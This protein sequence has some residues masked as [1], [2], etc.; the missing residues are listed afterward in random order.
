M[1]T[2]PP[3]SELN[4]ALLSLEGLLWGITADDMINRKEMEKLRQWKAEH[5]EKIHH[6][7]VADL[8]RMLD[9]IMECHILKEEEKAFLEAFCADYGHC[10][11]G[12][13]SLNCD[14]IRLSG[15]IQGILADK[16]V[17]EAEIRSFRR[18]LEERPHLAGLAVYPALLERCGL[19]L[20]DRQIDGAALYRFLEETLPS[21]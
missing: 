17:Y 14:R 21:L 1:K 7:P 4:R 5:Y 3:V 20:E 6:H 12:A 19:F 8:I 15:Y 13:D 18:W 9:S 2:N 10:E 16:R 11:E